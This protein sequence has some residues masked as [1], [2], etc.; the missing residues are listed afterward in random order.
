MYTAFFA[1]TTLVF[2]ARSMLAMVRMCRMEYFPESSTHPLTRRR[3]E[4]HCRLKIGTMLMISIDFVALV[5]SCTSCC[6][7]CGSSLIFLFLLVACCTLHQQYAL[8]FTCSS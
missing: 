7:S 5:H 6:S 1:A 3:Q 8:I 2:F 4:N